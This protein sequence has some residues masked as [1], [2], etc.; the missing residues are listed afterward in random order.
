ML[1][2]KAV[3]EFGVHVIIKR[4]KQRKGRKGCFFKFSSAQGLELAVSLLHIS[5]VSSHLK[6]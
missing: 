6:G 5:L 3:A 2:C 1:A 4:K